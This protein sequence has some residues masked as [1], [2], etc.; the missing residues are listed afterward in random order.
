MNC[1]EDF[2]RLLKEHIRISRIV[3]KHFLKVGKKET[4][5]YIEHDVIIVDGVSKLKTVVH[6]LPHRR[7]YTNGGE[8]FSNPHQVYEMEEDIEV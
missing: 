6:L 3:S 7:M 2:N 4:S 5:T 8:K 1:R